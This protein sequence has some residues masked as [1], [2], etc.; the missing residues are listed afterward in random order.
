MVNTT[1]DY[2][3]EASDNTTNYYQQKAIG[4]HEDEDYVPSPNED[5]DELDIKQQK[6]TPRWKKKGL[7]FIL[8][9]Y[10]ALIPVNR[11]QREG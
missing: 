3:Q 5:D 6:K 8:Y 4:S 2:Q 10:Q 1:N 11:P 7:A 9:S